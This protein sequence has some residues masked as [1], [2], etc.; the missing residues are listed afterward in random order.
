MGL[1]PDAAGL[2]FDP[3]GYRP[4]AAAVA[5][6]TI[7]VTGASTGIGRA[8]ALALGRA[9]ATVVL[10]ARQSRPLE[11][12]YDE[13]RAADAPTPAILAL[14]FASAAY[15]DYERLAETLASEFGHLDGLVVNAAT[16]GA[17]A[18]IALLDPVQWGRVLH[19]NLNSAFM[20]VQNLLP[21]LD[22]S[23]D[24]TVVFSVDGRVDRGRAYW[25][26][27]AAA[28]A[29]LT[30][31]ARTLADE[32]AAAG[33]PRV[34]C[35]DPGPHVTALRR[36]AFPGEAADRWPTPARAAPAYLYLCGA[37]SAGVHGRTL[38]LP[39]HS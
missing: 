3:D 36:A 21:L 5:G 8:A 9:G 14:D 29:G 18:P 38:A 33:R 31:F 10:L 6:R 15:P 12:V 25:G 11:R 23:A 37:D 24:P 39:A 27:Y 16:L 22:K 2:A 17:L 26:P 7:L 35:I 20:L 1:S 32:S 30:A 28:K 4:T 34:N 13:L 19:V